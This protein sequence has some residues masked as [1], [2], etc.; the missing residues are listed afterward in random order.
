MEV[1]YA[2]R[3]NQPRSRRRTAQYSLPALPGATTTTCPGTPTTSPVNGVP[4]SNPVEDLIQRAP[5]LQSVET[6]PYVPMVEL[7]ATR[8]VMPNTVRLD[9]RAAPSGQMSQMAETRCRARANST[10]WTPLTRHHRCG[11]TRPQPRR[12]ESHSGSATTTLRQL[13][14]GTVL[15]MRDD[16]VTRLD[17]TTCC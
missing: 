8:A 7:V 3:S 13:A 9:A 2:L 17:D 1:T 14:G 4:A 15:V 6:L 10:C 11:L 12:W 5:R 16:T